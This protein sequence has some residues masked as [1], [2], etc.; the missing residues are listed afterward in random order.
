MRWPTPRMMAKCVAIWMKQNIKRDGA[1]LMTM[2]TDPA[3]PTVAKN[4]RTERHA[5]QLIFMHSCVRQIASSMDH[6]V[7]HYTRSVE[8]MHMLD[9]PAYKPHKS[10]T[11]L[12]SS[13]SAHMFIRMVAMPS[14][15]GTKNES[16]AGIAVARTT[17][18]TCGTPLKKNLWLP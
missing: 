2:L 17:A 10:P 18:R 11:L 4:L 1:V 8:S 16:S 7:P 3:A 5:D 14:A 9:N 12:Q 15:D 13:R 6:N